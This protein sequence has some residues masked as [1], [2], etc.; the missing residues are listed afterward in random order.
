MKS[1]PWLQTGIPTPTPH[2]ARA[3]EDQ[4]VQACCGRVRTD[5]QHTH[6]YPVIKLPISILGL[7]TPR[8][9]TIT[10]FPLLESREPHCLHACGCAPIFLRCHQPPALLLL[11]LRQSPQAGVWGG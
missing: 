9:T 4:N 11:I 5:F 6:C 8:H 3:S 1:I 10:A 7:G 2:A